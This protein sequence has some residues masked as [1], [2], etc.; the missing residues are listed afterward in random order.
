MTNVRY[1]LDQ[2]LI[3][4][5]METKNVILETKACHL[6]ICLYTNAP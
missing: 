2:S 3:V 5:R 1:E 4:V 6:A